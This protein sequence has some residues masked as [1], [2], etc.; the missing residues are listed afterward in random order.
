MR[1]YKVQG[2]KERWWHRFEC[3]STDYCSPLTESGNPWS[4]WLL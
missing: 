4:H 2:R 3:S 1:R